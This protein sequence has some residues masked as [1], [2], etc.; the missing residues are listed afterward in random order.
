MSN[1]HDT[2][3][4]RDEY[5][6]RNENGDVVPRT[7]LG[8][9][10]A[11]CSSCHAFKGFDFYANLQGGMK[12]AERDLKAYCAKNHELESELV[13]ATIS[14]RIIEREEKRILARAQRLNKYFDL[15]GDSTVF[16]Y[17]V[18]LV[19]SAI[20]FFWIFQSGVLFQQV[21]RLNV[22]EMVLRD[23]IETHRAQKADDRCIEDDDRLYEALGDGIKCDRRVG[24]K[25]AML[26]NCERFIDRRCV[27]GHWP[28]YVELEQEIERL[29]W[30]VEAQRVAIDSTSGSSQVVRCAYCQS[31]IENGG[32]FFAPSSNLCSTRCVDQY[33]KDQ[34]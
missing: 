32:F 14:A 30:V 16:P 8:T 23:A 19:V 28:T 34:L 6:Y 9:E 18:I 3:L 1:Q 10:E 11:Y 4:E 21:A 24:D 12:L 26:R 33:M 2:I 31:V 25:A 27:A 20:A 13:L 22:R 5:S 17:I 29:R 15:E 7:L